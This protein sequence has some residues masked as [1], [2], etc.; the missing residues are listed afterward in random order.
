LAGV[1]S[2]PIVEPPKT[3]LQFLTE[4]VEKHFKVRHIEGDRFRVA[5]FTRETV[6]GAPV[7]QESEA[8]DRA[9]DALRVEIKAASYVPTLRRI[10]DDGIITVSKVIDPEFRSSRVNWLFFVATIATVQWSGALWWASY[11]SPHGPTGTEPGVDWLSAEAM[12][13]G[14]AYFTLP[15]IAILGLHEMGH[16]L[17]ARHYNVRASLP[18][19]IPSIFPLGTFGAFIAMR[20]PLPSRRAI[21]DIGLSGP[22]V[23]FL[24]S[25]VVTVAGVLLTQTSP[26]APRPEVGGQLSL[27]TPLIFQWIVSAMGAP[28]SYLHPTLFAGW[29][30]FLVTAFNLIPAAQ[31]DGGHVFFSLLN[32]GARRESQAVMVSVLAVLGVALMGSLFGYNGWLVLVILVFLTIRH[33]PP[34]NQLSSLGWKRLAAGAVGLLV[35]AISFSPAPLTLIPADYTFDVIAPEGAIAV[36]AGGFA[37]YSFWVNNTGNA[38]NPITVE[39]H[40]SSGAFDALFNGTGVRTTVLT[41]MVEFE[42]VEVNVT[43]AALTRAVGEQGYV[44]LSLWPSNEPSYVKSLFITAITVPPHPSLELTV[45]TPANVTAGSD[46]PSTMHL[47]NSGDVP[48]NLTISVTSKSPDWQTGFGDLAYNT[49]NATLVPGQTHDFTFVAHV[50]GGP[51]G[52]AVGAN[53]TFIVQALDPSWPTGGDAVAVELTV[54]A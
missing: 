46:V 10:G 48:Q 34:L 43:V 30:G 54:T 37:N 44:Q 27:G 26:A 16:F 24:A 25:I 29:A 17:M 7:A 51:G 32:N 49:T 11:I 22:L 21:F 35:F 45:E 52:A 39:F 1:P 36:P 3:V 13:G 40:S 12:M 41:N 15:L 20:D 38:F 9:Y 33:P 53:A 42:Q 4:A 50:P 14:L 8:V 6:D 19:F 18:F 28:P 47:R 31:L 2:Q 23:G 5:F